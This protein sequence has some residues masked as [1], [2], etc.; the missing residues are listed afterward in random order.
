MKSSWNISSPILDQGGCTPK[1]LSLPLPSYGIPTMCCF[2]SQNSSGS[3]F[4]SAYGGSS[5]RTQKLCL[6]FR[7]SSKR[8]CRRCTI[9]PE[10]RYRNQLQL[11]LTPN[12][13]RC[14]SR[15]AEAVAFLLL[16]LR[17]SS[18]LSLVQRR[19][20]PIESRKLLIQLF[21]MCPSV[22]QF[23]PPSIHFHSSSPTL[24]L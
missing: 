14:R 4:R 12:D 6:R 17:G 2:R 11:N 9:R 15:Q 16:R 19:R 7:N 22:S 5:S 24:Q 21:P 23:E 1:T 18:L 20:R 13:P 3:S 8:R 10:H